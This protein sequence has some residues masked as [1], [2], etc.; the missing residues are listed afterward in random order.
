LDCSEA[1]NQVPDTESLNEWFLNAPAPFAS[2]W[3]APGEVRIDGANLLSTMGRRINPDRKTQRALL[4]RF[5]NLKTKSDQEILDFAREWGVLGI[6]EH[7][8]PAGHQ[9]TVLGNWTT[10]EALPEIERAVRNGL[11]FKIKLKKSTDLPRPFVEQACECPKQDGWFCEPLQKWRH[12]AEQ[13]SAILKLAVEFRS[14]KIGTKEDWEIAMREWL[15]DNPGCDVYGVDETATG[16]S[17]L[18]VIITHWLRVN[19]V[20]PVFE[21][22]STDLGIKLR[23]P[24]LGNWFLLPVLAMQLMLEVSN[25]LQ[26]AMCSG[27]NEPFL[28]DRGQSLHRNSYCQQC[29]KRR[30]PQQRAT[31]KYLQKERKSPNRKKRIALT[32]NLVSSIKS[33]LKKG[34]SAKALGK[35]YGVSKWTIY[36]IGQGK[37]WANVK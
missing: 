26:V 19:D 5:A 34:K 29:R 22:S 23:S 10:P 33:S 4:I 9:L 13:M 20:R 35:K 27:C 36:K 11:G 3:I 14:G 6:C 16:R 17:K 2:G 15:I 7:G 24:A 1:T 8:R 28:L 12:Y 37:N 21:W 31:Q 30:I 18:A 32:E 25:S